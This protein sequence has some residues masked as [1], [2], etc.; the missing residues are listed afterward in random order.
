MLSRANLAQL[1]DDLALQLRQQELE[2]GSK[3]HFVSSDS[4]ELASEGAARTALPLADVDDQQTNNVDDSVSMVLNL[5]NADDHDLHTATQSNDDQPTQRDSS[6]DSNQLH[7]HHH[8]HQHQHEQPSNVERRYPMLSMGASASHD[9]A[10]SH[11]NQQQ[12]QMPTIG[13]DERRLSIMLHRHSDD[14]DALDRRHD[15]VAHHSLNSLIAL[16]VINY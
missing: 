13:E 16:S 7:H 11:N 12:Q 14:N 3:S 5:P 15:I 4:V 6:T 8:Q 10:T 1:E 9:I 2:H